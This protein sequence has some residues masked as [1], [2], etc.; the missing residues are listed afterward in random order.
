MWLL[1]ITMPDNKN[2]FIHF[3][4]PV[5]HY[6]D[7]LSQNSKCYC[8]FYKLFRVFYML[9]ISHPLCWSHRTN[10][11]WIRH[12]VVYWCKARF[13]GVRKLKSYYLWA[14]DP[15]IEPI[16]V[17]SKFETHVL[18]IA[19]FSCIFLTLFFII[20]TITDVPILPPLPTS[21]QTL[22][23]LPSGHRHTVVC[24][25]GFCTRVLCLILSPSFIWPIGSF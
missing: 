10:L 11:C 16:I 13:R 24:V 19:S 6:S 12:Q 2:L 15:E 22:P 7:A 3:P 8:R 4:F 21:T 25:C 23:P 18:S 1:L 14:T 20:Y 17:L 9:R 5:L